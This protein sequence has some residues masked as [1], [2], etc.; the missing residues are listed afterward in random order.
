MRYL[1]VMIQHNLFMRVQRGRTK[2]K[3]LLVCALL[4]C[5]MMA[6][7]VFTAALTTLIVGL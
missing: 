6:A 7:M 5:V 3:S 4:D 2:R 1:A